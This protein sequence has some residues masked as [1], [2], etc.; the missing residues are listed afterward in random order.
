MN[1]VTKKFFGMF[2]VMKNITNLNWWT[3]T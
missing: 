3:S 1:F 2:I